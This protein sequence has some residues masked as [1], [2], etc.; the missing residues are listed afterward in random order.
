MC[1]AKRSVEKLVAFLIY[2]MSGRGGAVVKMDGGGGAGVMSYPILKLL[3]RKLP[4]YQK[5]LEDYL[6]GSGLQ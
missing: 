2:I 6:K 3:K 5:P 4:S 1:I